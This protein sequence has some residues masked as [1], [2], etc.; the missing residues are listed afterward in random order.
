MQ[1]KVQ[2]ITGSAVK[3]YSNARIKD[4]RKQVASLLSTGWTDGYIFF[5]VGIAAYNAGDTKTAIRLYEKSI[6]LTPNP[7][8]KN[9]SL[10]MALG[11]A[12]SALDDYEKAFQFFETSLELDPGNANAL[13]NR[14]LTH[15][16]YGNSSLAE[17]EF[18]AA[19]ALSPGTIGFLLNLGDLLVGENRSDEALDL[20]KNGLALHSENPEIHIKMGDLLKEDSALDAFRHYRKAVYLAP[21]NETYLQKYSRILPKT[22]QIADI[23]S[24][25]ND[26]LLLLSSNAIQWNHLNRIV[27]QYIRSRP[28]FGSHLPALTQSVQSNQEL[29]L[30]LGE[31][32]K[33]LSDKVLLLAL[34]NMRIT[35]PEIEKMLEH[36]RRLTLTAICSGAKLEKPLC[37]LLRAFLI[38]LAQYSFFTEYLF[39]END[40]ESRAVNSLIEY[41]EGDAKGSSDEIILRYLVL[42]CYRQCQKYSFSKDLLKKP[43]FKNQ[44][45]LE[46]L[47]KTQITEPE[48][49]LAAQKK[50]RT[51]TKID[52]AISLSV[53]EQYEENP[54]PRWQNL[55]SAGISSYA[56]DI[57]NKLPILRGQQPNFPKNPQVLIAGCGTGRQ[58]ISSAKAYPDSDIL[59][60]DLSLASISYAMRKAE[61]SKVKN[62]EFGQADIM[63]LGSLNRKFHIIECAGVLHHMNDPIAGWNVLCDL[64]E[65]DGYMNIGLYSELGRKD[66][67]ACREYITENEYG[68]TAE[69]IRTCRK[70]LMALEKTHPAS[71]I[72]N[73]NDFYTL[74]ACRDLIFHVQEH[75]FTVERISS[76]LEELGLEFLGFNL[77]AE[78]Y[79][80]KYENRFPDDT[81]R[82]NLDNWALFEEENPN[83]FAT[84][85]K[86]WVR[87]KRD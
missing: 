51:I 14:G 34:K 1:K 65:D 42:S 37:D 2:K 12:Y 63:E 11:S 58:P 75:R 29:Q 32:I 44:P 82:T 19:L 17:K 48:I 67:I 10:F 5:Q 73:H 25:G 4:A 33:A 8:K 40:F 15:L 3:L 22:P 76:A 74:S 66:V 54:Y 49:E 62:I 28:A 85:Y 70:A 81:T 35:D 77:D 71:H 30:D 64:L 13:N 45:D 55:P 41:F 23:D 79:V 7:E 59:A 56:V 18:N 6:G 46:A 83:V 38:P 60:I 9:S 43:A 68:D 36:F 57:S 86:F 53:R 61:E 69:E 87:K 84:M 21:K 16:K 39:Q 26:L 72:V 50:I 20:Y 52:D 27:R 80:L 78:M 24:M 47:I 31:V